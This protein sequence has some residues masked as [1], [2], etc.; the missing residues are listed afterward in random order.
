M[1]MVFAVVTYGLPDGTD[2]KTAVQMF[3][4]S[5]PRYMSTPGLLRKNVLYRNGLG[6]GA[7]LFESREAADAAF[8]KNWKEYMTAKYDHPPEI[9]IYEMPDRKSVV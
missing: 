6:G 5:I 3:R 2:R 9:E 4:D 7:Y 1:T 8:N